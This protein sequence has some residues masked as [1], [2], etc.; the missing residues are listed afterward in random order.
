MKNPKNTVVKKECHS[1]GMLPG[2]FHIPGRCSN[3]IKPNALYYNNTK[4]GD[5]RQKPSGMIPYFITARGFTLIELLVVVLIIGILAAVALPQYKVAVVKS[6]VGTMLSL[7]G[8][9][10][11]AEEAYYLANGNYAPFN[12]L[13]ID[14]PKGCTLI[15][16]I[17]GTTSNYA[18]G[19]DFVFYLSEAN[20][21]NINYC[22]GNNATSED[23]L[24]T[25]EIHIPFR[26]QHFIYAGEE[27]ERLCSV[28]NNSK[29]GKA[30]C[31]SLAGFKCKGC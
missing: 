25:R 13:D 3:L 6:R 30:V 12:L 8:S 16:G 22:P 29:L 27:G 20:S 14:I 1:R 17:E 23:C 10:A 18:C 15:E 2:I 26:L 24:D 28:K 4:A 21:V 31:S 9:I 5:P 7:A 11:A 19:K